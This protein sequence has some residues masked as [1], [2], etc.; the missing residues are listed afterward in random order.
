MKLL[1]F[2]FSVTNQDPGFVEYAQPALAESNVETH[3]AA[4]GGLQPV[5]GRHLLPAILD[6]HKPDMLVL[7][8]ATAIYRSGPP[9]TEEHTETL[10]AAFRE[11]ARRGIRCGMLDFARVDLDSA[12]DWLGAVH[13]RLCLEFSVPRLHLLPEASLLKDEVHTNEAGS[14]RYASALEQLVAE[15]RRQDVAWK[16]VPARKSF[17]AIGVADLLAGH[18][19]IRLFQRG[20]YQT[21][22]VKVRADSPVTVQ[23]STPRRVVGVTVLMGPTTGALDVTLDDEVATIMAYDLHCYYERIGGRSLPGRLVQRLS[24]AQSPATPTIQLARK[25]D[26]ALL[27]S[28]ELDGPRTGGVARL[29]VEDL[30]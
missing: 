29:L 11:C 28:V 24:F 23:L 27:K 26:P 18:P 9:Q 8:I 13:Q 15:M 19:D 12:K 7:E 6:E 20:G 21:S 30:I 25:P 22:I 4:V 3:K 14:R 1:V 2:G 16:D 5:H 10:L 17:D